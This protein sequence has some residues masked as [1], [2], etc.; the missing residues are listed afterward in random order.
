MS[1]TPSKVQ[2][3][4]LDGTVDTDR[5]FSK[6]E[7][8]IDNPSELTVKTDVPASS[9]TTSVS[10]EDASFA[11]N[12]SAYNSRDLTAKHE[13]D[14]GALHFRI[15]R[16]DGAQQHMIWL[17]Q[18][19]NIFAT[20]LPKMPREYIARLVFDRKHRSLIAV[21]NNKVVGGICFRPFISNHF[22]EIAFCAVTSSEQVK[23]YGTRLMNH[24]KEATK[25]DGINHFLTYADNYAIGY[26]KKQGFTKSISM[27]SEQ[28]VGYIKDYDGGTLMECTFYHSIDY[29]DVPGLVKNQR[30]Q[31]LA[32]FKE[33]N[34]ANPVYPGLKFPATPGSP[35]NSASQPQTSQNNLEHHLQHLD[36]IPG[37]VEA[38]YNINELATKIK[39]STSKQ[40]LSVLVFDARKLSH[41]L[42]NYVSLLKNHEDSW[43]FRAPVDTNVIVD[44]CAKIAPSTPIDLSLIEKNVNSLQYTTLEQ[45]L[46]DVH[47]MIQNCKVYNAPDTEYFSQA[48]K[49]EA[50]VNAR[51]P[52]WID[53][54]SKLVTYK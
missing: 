29:L 18:A 26:F 21:K 37:L 4:R 8:D 19:K 34:E 33:R 39:L 50:Y 22:A 43:P 28:W 20:Q 48:R 10:V 3:E 16:N 13:E 5:F 23:G 7:M 54:V 27:P 35:K 51:T 1:R 15:I 45:F 53:G 44:Y 2:R 40:D 47:M 41:I 6:N 12:S 24:L 36:K 38:G 31:I 49:L 42:S 14:A 9:S 52:S 17:T 46:K 30:N 25:L 11:T 32:A